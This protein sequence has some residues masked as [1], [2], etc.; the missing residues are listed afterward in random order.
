MWRKWDENVLKFRIDVCCKCSQT[1]APKPEV[2]S[3]ISFG[4][5]EET[6][7]HTETDRFGHIA[8]SLS[9]QYFEQ[10]TP[11]FI[12]ILFAFAFTVDLAVFIVAFSVARSQFNKL[13][14]H[15]S[16][17][18]FCSHFRCSNVD[19]NPRSLQRAQQ[20]STQREIT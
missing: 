19:N 1:W 15:V 9:E 20:G 16:L 14:T 13:I 5:Y 6:V 4:G 11:S 18:D 3:T 10:S 7:G 2:V 8:S 12:W 17:F